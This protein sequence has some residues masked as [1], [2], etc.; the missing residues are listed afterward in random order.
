[1]DKVQNRSAEIN[2]R[3]IGTDLSGADATKIK[4]KVGRNMLKEVS[5]SIRGGKCKA[6]FGNQH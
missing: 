6:I 3:V 1:M 2:D 4:V 5:E